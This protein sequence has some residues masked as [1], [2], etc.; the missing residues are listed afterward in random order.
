MK[1]SH[2]KAKRIS[3][4]GCIVKVLIAED[5]M[6]S[7]RLLEAML[8]RWGYEV[9]VTR[10]GLEA[11]HVLQTANTSLL[12][13]LDW[14]MPGIDGV[15]VCRRVRQRGQEPY[16]YLLLLTTKGRKENI[17][18]G[19]E[20]GADDYLTKPFDPHELQVRLR[21]GK[22]IVTL[23][24][25]LIEAREALRIQATHDP[26]TNIWNRRAIIETLSNELARAGREGVPVA[27]VL[28]DLDYFKRINDTYGHV[29]GDAVLCEATNRM[30]AS[31]RTYDTIGRYGGE[32]F[33]ILLPNC[34]A[35]DAVKLA[36][37]LRLNLSQET[38][39]ICG[40]QIMITSSLGVASSDVLKASDAASL[41][42]AADA[43]LY[44]AKAGGRNRVELAVVTDCITNMPFA[45]TI[46]HTGNSIEL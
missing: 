29:A 23:Q 38:M 35:Q 19:L 21:A 37:R 11:W 4:G 12:A 45:E 17:I 34:T 3:Q 40:H 41:I 25:E 15:E 27:V 43:A 6:V 46:L 14:I 44:R 39:Q 30:R 33:L 10:D 1:T 42:R 8:S 28:A 2:T 24:A 5:D 13:I 18:E 9:V 31:L 36:D 16:I 32:E 22:R 26:L 7:R 20:A